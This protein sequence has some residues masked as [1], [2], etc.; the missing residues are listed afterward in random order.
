MNIFI[1]GSGT[2][3]T[4]IANE[5]ARNINNKVTIFSRS[6]E[7]KNEINNFHT[8]KKY[9][10]NKKLSHSLLCTNE[11]SDIQN[12]D[13]IF[14]ALPSSS[15]IENVK[16]FSNYIS[17]N[18][19]VVNL[20]KGILSSG[21]TI[22]EFLK[23]ELKSD[24]LVSLKG[25]SFAVEIIE[26]ADTILTLGYSTKKQKEI[27]F[28]IFNST[29]IYLESTKDIKGVE[30]L[31]VIKNIYAIILGIV[32]EKF[33]FTNSR[34]MILSKVFDEIKVLNNE[35]NGDTKTLFLACGLGDICL[36]SFNNLSRNRTLGKKIGKGCYDSKEKN[37]IVVE[38]VHSL[39]IIMSLLDSTTQKK[40]PL[41]NK[42]FLFFD[43]ELN[44]IE[45]D[46][47]EIYK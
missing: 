8:N 15:I 16:F 46:L 44:E 28:K 14:L 11:Y 17:A 41:L 47:K 38:G 27:I 25:P 36:T 19:L 5:L 45:L 42:L 34:F 9:F 26:R 4:A 37:E 30:I 32:D 2:F 21:R 23:T 40:L 31:G 33:S 35:F 3:G 29:C 39:K 24:N 12:A 22:I 10:P 6:E 43:S 18:Q 13:V 1:I 20:S 7:K